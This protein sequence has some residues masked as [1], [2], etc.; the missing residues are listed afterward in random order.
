MF[1]IREERDYLVQDD[2]N[3]AARKLQDMKKLEGKL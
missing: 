2:L 1:A 3:K